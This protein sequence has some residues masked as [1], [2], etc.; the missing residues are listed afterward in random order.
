M[1]ATY[2]AAAIAAALGLSGPAHAA[3]TPTVSIPNDTQPDGVLDPGEVLVFNSLGKGE[4]GTDTL[5]F[6]F[7]VSTPTILGTSSGTDFS[8]L[9]GVQFVS[10]SLNGTNIGT[11]VETGLISFAGV[12]LAGGFNTFTLNFDVPEG[13]FAFISGELATVPLPAGAWLMIGGLGALG[14]YG[15]RARRTTAASA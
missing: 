9:E 8:D 12:A 13:S 1:K 10:A 2:F 4:A 3:F 11:K 5:T 7:E 14:A 15:R 6:D